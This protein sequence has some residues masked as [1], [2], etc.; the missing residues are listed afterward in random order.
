[1]RVR[2]SDVEISYTRSS[3][4]GGQNVNKLSTRCQ[5]RVA[6]DSLTM[7]PFAKDRLATLAGRTLIEGGF[8]LIDAQEHRS[9]SRN[10]EACFEKLRELIVRALVRP[11][12]RRKTRPSKGS[13]ERRLTAK[14][15]RGQIKRDRRAE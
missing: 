10:R 11:K 9:Q 5:L 1:V 14:K 6:V 3:G 4:P 8:L 12:P 7:D 15:I 13:V 2:E